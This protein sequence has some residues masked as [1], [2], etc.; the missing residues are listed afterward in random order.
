MYQI[1]F[2]IPLSSINDSLPDLPIYGYGTMLFIAFVFCFWLGR[3]LARREGAP[4]T[5]IEDVAPWIIVV[6][7]LGAR[8]T[9]F[10]QF[11]NQFANV[12]QFFAI[13][14]GGLVFYGGAFGAAVGYF[15]A[16]FLYLRKRGI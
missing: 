1:L 13:W 4:P 9:F 5:I 7:I 14:D 16:Y 3:R 11:R 15:L 12:G 6:G 2:T 8:F 10:L